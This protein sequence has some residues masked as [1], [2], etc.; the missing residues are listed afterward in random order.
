M[1][2]YY[3]DNNVIVNDINIISSDDAHIYK[4]IQNTDECFNGFGEIYGS[5]IKKDQIKAWKYQNKNIMNLFVPYGSVKLVCY[6]NNK[7]FEVIMSEQNTKRITVR[8]NIYYGFK[9]IGEKNL[10][11]NLIN[12]IHDENSSIN[13]PLS[14]L[15][16]EW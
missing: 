11:L 10:I 9:G 7:F 13:K 3:L 2:N 16:Y 4:Y 1:K 8:P 6:Y 12:N 5:L 14:H 15:S